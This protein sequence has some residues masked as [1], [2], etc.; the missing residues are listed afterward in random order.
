[1][2]AHPAIRS[3]VL[4][5]PSPFLVFD[6]VSLQWPDGSYA[7][8][9]VSGSIGAGRTGLVGRNGAGKSTLLRIAAGLAAPT[10]G[11]VSAS[12]PVAML[13]QRLAVDP[14][15]PVAS[16]LGVEGPL[17]AL[18]AIEAGDVDPRPFDAAVSYT[19]L[20][21]PTIYPV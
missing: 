10:S 18:R 19:H 7:L 2:S 1:M 6:R 21:L 12:G 4:S 13:P 15:R 5:S 14:D 20:T 11:H 9:D 16:L 8:R 17:R 3:P